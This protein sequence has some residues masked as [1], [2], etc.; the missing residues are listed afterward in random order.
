M[1][2]VKETQEPISFE[3]FTKEFLGRVKQVPP[4]SRFRVEVVT[5]ASG[6]IHNHRYEL[7]EDKGKVSRRTK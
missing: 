4:S 3:E 1:D 5:N 2:R 6:E 7:A